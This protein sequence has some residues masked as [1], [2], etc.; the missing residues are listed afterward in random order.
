MESHSHAPS[1]GSV[2]RA[3]AKG[4]AILVVSG[5]VSGSDGGNVR[6]GLWVVGGG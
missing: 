5:R 6:C 1:D 3:K 2:P 4:L